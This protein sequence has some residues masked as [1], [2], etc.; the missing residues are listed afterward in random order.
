MPH[1][2]GARARCVTALALAAVSSIGAQ[3]EQRALRPADLYL[4]HDV[5]DP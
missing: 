2:L 1:T 4:F 3:S 5:R